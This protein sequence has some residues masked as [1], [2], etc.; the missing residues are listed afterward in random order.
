MRLQYVEVTQQEQQILEPSHGQFFYTCNSDVH[1][2]TTQMKPEFEVV[3]QIKIHSFHGQPSLDW[4]TLPPYH[5][6]TCSGLNRPC[7]H[8]YSMLMIW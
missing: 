2:C 3:K 6:L 8:W 4:N 5:F 1:E 7:N